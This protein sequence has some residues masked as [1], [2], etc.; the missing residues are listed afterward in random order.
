M[1]NTTG[2]DGLPRVPRR[3]EEAGLVAVPK[4]EELAADPSKAWTL[5]TQTARKLAA[6]GLRQTATGLAASLALIYRLLDQLSG[7]EESGGRRVDALRTGNL[8]DI[9][10][11]D[12]VAKVFGKDADWL[13]RNAAGFPFIKRVSR[14]NSVCLK[15]ELM[16]WLA[17]RP[18]PKRRG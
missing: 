6:N 18:T 8:D 3:S 5:D 14:K 11:I 13:K 2:D 12:E 10:T 7:E 17:A 16:R 1:R 9:A 4:L 15:S